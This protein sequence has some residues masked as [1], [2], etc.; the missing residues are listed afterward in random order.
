MLHNRAIGRRS[1]SNQVKEGISTL[2]AA[3]N[4]GVRARVCMCV[5]LVG[6]GFRL[7]KNKSLQCYSEL[8]NRVIHTV[9]KIRGFTD[10]SL[11]YDTDVDNNDCV[12]T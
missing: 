4:I 5:S 7:W 2:S 12:I 3:E 11:N 9:K 8:E 1:N 10:D 6:W